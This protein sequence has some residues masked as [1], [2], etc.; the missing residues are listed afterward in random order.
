MPKLTLTNCYENKT[1]LV[2]L[3]LSESFTTE[4]ELLPFYK[5][6]QLIS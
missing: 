4:V 6:A 2:R 3:F 1:E 5:T